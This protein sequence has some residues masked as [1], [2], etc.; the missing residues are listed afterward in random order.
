MPIFAAVW[1]W[2]TC[3]QSLRAGDAPAVD[4]MGREHLENV[5]REHLENVNRQIS[6]SE[7][8]VAEWSTLIETRRAEGHDVT[9]AN[10]LL[11]TFRRNLEVHR[12]NHALIQR[13]VEEGAA[14]AARAAVTTA[15]RAT[16]ARAN[17]TA[18]GE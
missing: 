11:E 17:A 4:R 16:V 2:T 6:E 5:R 14:G 8:I 13:R 15:D 3:T 12:S 9:V 18:A 1:P 7:R 10:D